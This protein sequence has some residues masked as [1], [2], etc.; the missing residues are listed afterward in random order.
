MVDID[1]H[2]ILKYQR[3]ETTPQEEALLLDYLNQSEAHR[4]E[5][6][7]ANFLY[8]ATLL[9]KG[10]RE[11][12]NRR[13][14]KWLA[15][16][17]SA[18]AAAILV[19]GLALYFQHDEA[20]GGPQPAIVVEAS[21][22]SQT[23]VILPDGSNVRLNAGSILTYPQP[24]DRT[25]N[26]DGEACFDVV[27]D[28]EVPFIVHTKGIAIRVTGTIFNVRA[29]PSDERVETMLA[30]GRVSLCDASGKT[31]FRLLP[32]EKVS[33]GWNGTHLEVSPV[34][35][36]ESLLDIYGSVTIPDTSLTALCAILGRV[37]G[38]RIRALADDGSLLTFSFS[39]CMPVKEVIA[40]LETISSTQFEIIK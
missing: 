24:F 20:T 7:R 38:V 37:Y 14:H 25:V 21:A 23:R 19:A 4:R 8:C 26:L 2:L 1:S 27:S 15:W 29:Y 3:C 17:L 39:K 31:L 34:N 32:G 30:S 13:L 28:P 16:G 6:D 10:R 18:A 9:H 22:L 5:M 36:W 35:A 33:C 40:R 12:K 11:E